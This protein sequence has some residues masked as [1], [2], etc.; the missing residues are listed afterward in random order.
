MIKIL[1]TADIHLGREFPFLREKG[2]EYRSQ[3]LRTFERI[4]DLAIAEDVSLLLIAGDLFDTNR[5]YGIIIDKVL[6]AFQK[7]EKQGIPVCVL[8]GTHD[9]YDEGSIY[10]FV[11]FPSNVTVFTPEHD[12]ETYGDLKLTVYGKAS[13]GRSVGE[14]PIQ[15]LSLVKESECH[16]GMAHCSVKIEGWIEHDTQI[17]DRNEIANSGFDYLA[18]GHWHSFQ[19]FSQGDTKAL[20]CGSPEPISMDQKG[21]GSVAMVTIHGKGGVTVDPVRVG[22]K[23]F[24]KMS[25]DVGSVKSMNAIIEMLEAKAAPNLILE[26]TLAG[27]CGMDYELNSQEIEDDLGGQFF[28][29]RV[30]D[31]SHPKLEQVEA[32]NIPEDTVAGRFVKIMQDRISSA[33]NE[34]DEEL[35]QEALRLGFA[36][37]QGRTR[38]IE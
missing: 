35:C 1:H 27:L 7:L 10:R 30:S 14:S 18:L 32:G 4:V 28:C 13:D 17:L 19:D 26:V 20:Y 38:V 37:L 24:D 31:E 34:E 9:V 5:V 22:S 25:I 36:L 11:R 12:H 23:Q 3:L 15:G 16:I 33:G 21:A 2:R 8:P 6:S 29:L